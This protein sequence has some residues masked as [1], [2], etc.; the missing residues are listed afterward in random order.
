[1]INN[2]FYDT[3]GDK[4]YEASDHP[5]ALLRAENVAR[6][7]WIAS[8]INASFSKNIKILDIGCGAGLLSNNL[9]LRGY[10][11]T[12]IDLSAPSLE[13]ATRYD[14]TRRVSYIQANAYHLPFGP[15]QFDVVCATDVLEH[16]ESPHLLIAEGSRVL[17]PGGLFFF[18]TFNRNFASWLIVIKGVEWFVKNTPPNMHV[19]SLF[20]RPDELSKM[21]KVH[22]LK[23]VEMRGLSP[24]LMSMPFLKML[25]TRK[26]TKDFQ[27][28]FNSSLLLGYC[29]FAKNK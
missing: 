11:V 7:D 24:K 26:V 25:L 17:K 21:L 28:I 15:A 6:A 13:V 12:G 16:V 19:Y 9:S 8:K 2:N 27:F 14:E 22:Q 5:V 20:I 29:G 3:L 1:M 18:H 4:W 10:G 23:I